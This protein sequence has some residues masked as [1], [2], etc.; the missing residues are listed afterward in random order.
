[1]ATA[2]E[3]A[4]KFRNRDERLRSTNRTE[5]GITMLDKTYEGEWVERDQP[6]EA[7]YRR[8]HP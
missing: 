7:T 6:G 3:M 4:R 5:K 1:M 8:R 2:Q